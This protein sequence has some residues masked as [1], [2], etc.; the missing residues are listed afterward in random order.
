MEIGEYLGLDCMLDRYR[1][2][3]VLT[4]FSGSSRREMVRICMWL[5]NCC[6]MSMLRRG[7]RWFPNQRADGKARMV[8]G[9]IRTVEEVRM[10]PPA[11]YF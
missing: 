5:I 10:R 9:Q 6:R 7:R 8:R 2:V 1:R 11:Y 4:S 3:R